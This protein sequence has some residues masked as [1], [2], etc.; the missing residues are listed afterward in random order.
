MKVKVAKW[1]NSL[2]VR[3]P[4]SAAETAGVSAGSELDL[5]V[6]GGGFRLR[7]VA[8]TSAQ[9]LEEMIAEMK[10]LG[11]DLEPE[12]VEWGPDRGSEIIDDDYSRGLIPGSRVPSIKSNTKKQRRG[13][14]A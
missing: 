11:P 3:L 6:E 14:L 2:G 9:L 13:K 5:T 8:K 7:S 10:R 4:K 1:G 12:T